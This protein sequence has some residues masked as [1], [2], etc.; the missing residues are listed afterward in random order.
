MRPNRVY[1]RTNAPIATV[2]SAMM[3]VGVM[4]QSPTWKRVDCS[5]RTDESSTRIDFRLTTNAR[6][7]A[8]KSPASEAMNG[9]TSKYWTRMP[10]SRPI[11]RTRDE[12]DRNGHH[13]GQSRRHRR[14]ASRIPVNAMTEPTDRSIPAVRMTNVMPTAMTIR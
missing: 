5:H 4:Y 6:P 14:L 1:C 13:R 9:C 12:D 11:T 3:P 2:N 10:M 8:R 7:R